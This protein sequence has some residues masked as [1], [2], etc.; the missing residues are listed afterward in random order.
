MV[1]AGFAKIDVTP[2]LGSPLAGYAR[3]RIS[4]G[5]L[6]PIELVALA[7]SDGENTALIITADFVGMWE[8]WATEIRGLI[9][10][11]TGV[12]AE[13]VYI[14]CLHQHTTVRIGWN[15]NVRKEMIANRFVDD[16]Y[17]NILYRK[18]VDV[19]KMAIDN[20][21]EARM[22]VAEQETEET[23]AF[24]RRFR[25]KD[26]S[27]KTNPQR[28]EMDQVEGPIGE[29]DNTVR[30][31]RFKRKGAK[32]IALVNFSTHPDVIGKTKFSADWPGFV[33][34]MTEAD[35]PDTHCIFVNG[36]EGDSN[37]INRF[38]ESPKRKQFGYAYSAH[39]GRVITD[40]VIDIW[41][42][43]TAKEVTKVSG[44]IRMNYIPTNT[45]LIDE[46]E[47]YKRLKEECKAGT[48]TPADM[49]EYAD[50]FRAAELRTQ[51]LFQ[52]VPLTVIAI[53]DVA[54]VGYG[55]EPF[56]QYAAD[57]RAANPDLFVIV[58]CNTNG[59]A[60]YLPTKEAFAEGGYESRSSNFTSELSDVLQQAVKEMIA[61]IKVKKREE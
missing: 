59:E 27:T 57:V 15:P 12:P 36:A 31:I 18:F 16:V 58:T 40:T 6:D 4:D 49:E 29:A 32:D 10:E 56:M 45:S 35:I 46:V 55:G 14:Q 11:E 53:G 20:L 39:I 33:R 51:P 17:Y 8:T 13:S 48:Y 44:Q 9:S 43:T 23:I 2:P 38:E 47:K 25:M 61:T 34:R 26:G 5:V 22:G 50:I 30:L 3:E 1:K 28:D 7:V 24:I 21:C 41:D 42:K 37:H 60:G 19:S 52:K 54:L